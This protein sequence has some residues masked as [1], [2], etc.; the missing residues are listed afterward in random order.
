MF[1]FIKTQTEL[2]AENQHRL[3]L[4]ENQL[5]NMGELLCSLS[6]NIPQS[7]HAQDLA[8]PKHTNNSMSDYDTYKINYKVDV[9]TFFKNVSKCD[10]IS[11]AGIIKFM[12]DVEKLS[13]LGILHEKPL[14][15]HLIQFCE[16]DFQRWWAH[17]IKHA[18]SWEVIR[19]RILDDFFGPADRSLLVSEHLH[20]WQKPEES[21]ISF[22][23]DIK[24]KAK[25]LGTS[26]SESEVIVLLWARMNRKTYDLCKFKA[27]PQSF[28][29]LDLVAREIRQI[30]DRESLYQEMEPRTEKS[31]NH[32]KTQ[33]NTKNF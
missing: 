17:N 24:L 10:G 8:E 29:D 31:D 16:G 27:I 19:G 3:Q 26:M 25:I 11:K 13:D 28:M 7:S 6:R 21:F 12:E 30:S 2:S 18:P 32:L 4:M 14:M 23:E 9:N 22:I 20:R 5:I 1:D 15:T 33:K